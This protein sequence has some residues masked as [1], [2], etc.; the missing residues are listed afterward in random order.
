MS[1]F[2]PT[3]LYLLLL[4]LIGKSVRVPHCPGNFVVATYFWYDINFP[5]WVIF[6][7]KL[8]RKDELATGV[9][10]Y[11]RV[12]PNMDLIFLESLAQPIRIRN[13]VYKSASELRISNI[14]NVNGFRAIRTRCSPT[15]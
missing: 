4:F 11:S 7:D 1:R 6:D 12:N 8:K 10:D 2:A 13:N 9:L 14:A 15:P 5:C 3:C